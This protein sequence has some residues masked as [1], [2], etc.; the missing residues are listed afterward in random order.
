MEKRIKEKR[1]RRKYRIYNSR[2]NKQ[3]CPARAGV[4][5]AEN[6]VKITD[7]TRPCYDLNRL[8]R[9]KLGTK[10]GAYIHWFEK[11]QGKVK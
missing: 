3:K 10:T 4:F 9:E 7:E 11:K 5:I 2:G 1:N 6:I 8:K